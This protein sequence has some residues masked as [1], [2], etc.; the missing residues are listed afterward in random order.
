M[1]LDVVADADTITRWFSLLGA[2]ADSA[3]K[4]D[5]VVLVLSESDPADVKA[6]VHL[7]HSGVVHVSPD[8]RDT[9]TRAAL[10]ADSRTGRAQV[11]LALKDARSAVKSVQR[12]GTVCLPA[13]D[14]DAPTITELVQRDV[15]LVGPSDI[16]S[17]AKGIEV[18]D[19]TRHLSAVLD[20]SRHPGVHA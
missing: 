11:V 5:D 14:V 9:E 15:R 19:L 13:A 6:L 1:G 4:A 8:G 7:W 18:S 10:R 12:G 17:I 2:F 16:T 3:R 20:Q